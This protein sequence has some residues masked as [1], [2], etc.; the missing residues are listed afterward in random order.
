MTDPT[1]IAGVLLVVGPVVG[2]IPVAHPA[3][4]RLWSSPRERYLEIIGAHRHAWYRLNAGFMLA[5]ISTAAGLAV[6]AAAADP[7]TARGS[8]MVAVA[9]AYAL[10][11]TPWLAMLAIRSVR[12]PLLADM[13]ADGRPTEPAETLLGAATSG[14]FVGFVYTTALT[15]LALAGV[16]AG[17]GGV[18]LPVA[19]MAGVIALFVLVIQL[20]S[21]DTIPA[22]LYLPTMLIGIALLFG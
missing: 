20:R 19:V 15:L 18:A 3:L 6:M 1:M 9:V 11:G 2:A 16:L 8:L 7:A 13:V 5:T 17:Q 22:V 14:L 12:D 4:V 10:G 21:G